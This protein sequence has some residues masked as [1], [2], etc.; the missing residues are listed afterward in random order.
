M[1]WFFA[2]VRR[3]V[4]QRTEAAAPMKRR[5]RPVSALPF[6][7]FLRTTNP[8]VERS[9]PSGRTIIQAASRG[10]RSSREHRAGGLVSTFKLIA[11][12]VLVA[13]AATLVQ[14]GRAEAL[15]PTTI[16][17][18][19]GAAVLVVTIIVVVIIANMRERQRGE[20]L[21]PASAPTVVA[22]DAAGVQS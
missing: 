20:A 7:V 1:C 19:V 18:I 10:A 9:P 21:E 3:M 4:W 8:T 13:V 15:E 12:V 16:I 11:L 14:P 5:F 17:T 22:Y 2:T 6:R